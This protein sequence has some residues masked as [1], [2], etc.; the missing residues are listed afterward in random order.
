MLSRRAF[1][2]SSAAYAA[3]LFAAP[4]SSKS[5][6]PDLEK[7]AAV[8]LREAKKLKATLLR[9]SHRT[10]RNQNVML[11]A[12]PDRDSGK[13][14][15][16]PNVL[17]DSSF[18]FGVRVIVNGAWGFASSPI[19][20][21]EEIVRITGE[22]VVIAKANARI[23]PQPGQLAPTKA[24]RERWVSPFERDPFQVPVAEKIDLLHNVVNEIKKNR[25]VFGGTAT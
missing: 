13:T 16:V 9:Y 3:H 12:T 17:E 10:L 15:E 4:Q 22:A 23:Q 24:Y 14:L 8:A 19:V 2:G 18:G 20:T 6:G 21:T 5:P 25:R 1:I 7:L 11:R